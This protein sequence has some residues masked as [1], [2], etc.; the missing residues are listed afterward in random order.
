MVRSLP[1]R[2]RW[3][4]LLVLAGCGHTLKTG[5][6]PLID[7]D[8]HPGLV[9]SGEVGTHLLSARVVALPLALRAELAATTEGVQG[10]I[11]VTYGLLFPAGGFRAHR[12]D[13]AREDE[14]SRRVS[15]SPRQP[16]PPTSP[17]DGYPPPLGVVEPEH[18][19]PPLGI[20][21]T[22]MKAAGRAWSG[23]GTFGVGALIDKHGVDSGWRGAIAL[24]R[25]KLRYVGPDGS[26]FC[27]G[28]HEKSRSCSSW[29]RWRY[30]HTGVE[31]ATTF[32]VV[33]G[34]GD[35]AGLDVIGWRVSVE[36]VHERGA[37]R[38]LN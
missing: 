4:A 1:G 12:G 31:L 21:P 7:S 10:L 15:T 18:H 19:P 25:G 35:E 34:A 20:P 3:I 16:P 24:T 33:R 9:V 30:A 17:T 23:R 32:R 11:G 8:G 14:P 29:D 28:S 6:G 26:G 36:L 38:D 22:R 27:L 2:M 37:L 13:A 5:A